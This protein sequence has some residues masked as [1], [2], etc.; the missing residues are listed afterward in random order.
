MKTRVVIAALVVA[1]GSAVSIPGPHPRAE[2]QTTT[3]ETRPNILVIVTDDQRADTLDVMP[4]TRRIFGR[5][6]VSYS[7]AY[8]STPLCCPFRAS[9]M[10]GQYAHNSGVK[11]QVNSNSLRQEQTIQYYL[12]QAGYNTAMAGK[13]LNNWAVTNEPSY[14][15]RWAM[16][17]TPVIDGGYYRANYNVDG[18]VKRI[19][20]YNADFL[21]SISKS[22]I[23]G[24]EQTDDTPWYLYLTPYAPHGPSQPAKRH[25]DAPIASWEGSPATAETDV[26]DKPPF[27][28]PS[29]GY[30]SPGEPK[31]QTAEKQRR[32]LLATDDLVKRLFNKLETLG[33]ADNTLA[34]YMSDNGYLLG[35]HG[36]KAKRYPYLESS[37]VPF[38][39]RWPGRLAPGTVDDRLVSNIDILPTAL[40]VAGITPVPDHL[41]DGR[42]LLSATARDRLLIEHFGDNS[43]H[44]PNWASIVT[45]TSQYVE[46]F[47]T[48]WSAVRFREYYDLVN[49]PYQLEN[50]LADP[51]PSNSPP[52]ERQ[53]TLSS[54][55]AADR[56]CAGVTCP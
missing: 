26:S 21:T 39:A 24:F 1:A 12:D 40:E 43:R 45:A 22:F 20:R 19:R 50:L 31:T 32:S 13:F 9:T 30:V 2:A 5:N 34:F 55:L 25:E 4:R 8:A 3:T 18:D 29:E 11:T 56:N 28:Y 16:M 14:F 51:D 38:M 17:R 54:Q 15:D 10:T 33:E 27:L 36:L 49:D 48:N 52:V 23:D 47:N 42:S 35:E 44:P 41:L 7:Q 37:R 6:G 46:Y 53:A